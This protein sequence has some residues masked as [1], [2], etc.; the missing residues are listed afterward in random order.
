MAAGLTYIPIASN[1]LSTTATTVTFS[2][3][4]STYTDLVLVIN[5]A[6]TGSYY[7]YTYFNS[8]TGANYSRTELN[9]S[10]GAA[11]S[12]RFSNLIPISFDTALGASL[13]KVNIMNYSNST[14][15]KT[16]S[17]RYDLP[18]GITG[19]G[20]GTWRST[21]AINRIDV[22]GYSTTTFV[23]GSTFTLYGITAA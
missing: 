23:A 16:C 13:N 20:I 22:V 15:Y 7:A 5:G 1:T 8:D 9:G 12:F 4:P 10:S 2:S 21:A 11:G 6:S 14:T 19:L 3:I 17:Y 18:N